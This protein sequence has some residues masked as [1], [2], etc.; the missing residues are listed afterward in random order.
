MTMTVLVQ[1]TDG[2]FKASLVGSPTLQVV[3]TSRHEA[4]AALERE[5]ASKIATGELVD[6]E[7]RPIGVSGLSGRFRDDPA[8]PGICDEIYEQRDAERTQ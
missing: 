4:I 1:K 7:L 6:L 2:Q 8:L 5:L 3:R